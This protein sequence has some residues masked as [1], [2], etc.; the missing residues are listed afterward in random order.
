MEM[1]RNNLF[2]IICGVLGAAGIALGVVGSK[3]MPK[4]LADMKKV[5]G[6]YQ[7]LNGLTS[8]PVNL[9]RI[10]NE[11]RR[12][13]MVL[14][15][16]Q[17]ILEKARTLYGYDPLVPDAFPDGVPLKL[18]EFRNKY[19]SKME[20]LF[21]SLRSGETASTAD[22]D[23]WRDKIENERAA[24]LEAGA[25][26]GASGPL[27]TPAGVLTPTG[28]REN[29]VARAH[30]AAAQRIQCYAIHWNSERLPDRVSTLEVH[31]DL[32]DSDAIQAPDVVSSWL[33]QV[34]YWIQKDVVDA[35]VALNHEVA[36]QA[37]QQSQPAWVGVM[38][39]KEVISIRLSDGY[40]RE[41][42]GQT[43][44]GPAEGFDASPPPGTPETVFTHTGSNA[45]FEVV[46]FSVKLVMDQ[47]DIPGFIQRLT[48]NRF[49]ALLDV[50]YSAPAVSFNKNF[51]GK[52]H[53]SEPVVM[54]VMNFETILLGDVFRPM[55]PPAVC[56]EFAI[57]CATQGTTAPT[58]GKPPK[59][60]K[61]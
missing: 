43:Y 4:V 37:A 42:G 12:A 53:G 35:I 13:E 56:E 22:I 19:H 52:I 25:E 6:I 9:D 55:M 60:E 23:Q 17:Q 45:S 11:K 30:L 51:V 10:E 61:P 16:R 50:S 46:Q 28:I 47:R 15:D 8:Q 21:A 20:E 14:E 33:A 1:L 49:H 5:E 18:I 57:P 32:R 54:V 27:E 48:R 59:G 58:G 41:T 2:F 24:Q 31:P 44:G 7:S 38:P 40:V 36:E 3:G 34:G 39:V 29:A 26:R